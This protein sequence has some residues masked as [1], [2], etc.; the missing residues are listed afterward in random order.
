MNLEND[1]WISDVLQSMKGSQRAQPR[2]DLFDQIEKVTDGFQ[3]SVVSFF[4]LRI[5][6]AAAVFLVMLNF[7][8]IYNYKSYVKMADSG[9]MESGNLDNGLISDY[10]I[11][12]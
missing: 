8:A 9:I 3:I 12:D 7:S 4:K 1:K 11:Y 2:P 5:A 10:N 6:I